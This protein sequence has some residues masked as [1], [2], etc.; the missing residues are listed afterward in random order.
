MGCRSLLTQ[1]R[2]YMLKEVTKTD[3]RWNLKETERMCV[4]Y[5]VK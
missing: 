4:Y 1:V 3:Y 2:R 5:A